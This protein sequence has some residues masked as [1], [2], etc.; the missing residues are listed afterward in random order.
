MRS[1][2]GSEFTVQEVVE[3]S[4]QSLRGFYQYFDGKDELLL[5]LPGE[6]VTVRIEREGD[7]I[8]A[9]DG[10][11]LAPLEASRVN[12][13]QIAIDAEGRRVFEYRKIAVYRVDA[14]VPPRD[15]VPGVR[16]RAVLVRKPDGDLAQAGVRLERG[17]FEPPS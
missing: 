17:F 2:S 9:R 4:G 14:I 7:R 8:V 3:R 11:I 15:G 5:A 1:D 12:V 6:A 13:A 10:R 16:L